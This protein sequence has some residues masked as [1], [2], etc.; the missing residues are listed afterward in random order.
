MPIR[1]RRRFLQVIDLES[2]DTGRDSY[3]MDI[4]GFIEFHGEM[5]IFYEFKYKNTPMPEGQRLAYAHVV[6]A[7][8]EAGKYAAALICE[9]DVDDADED[10]TAGETIIRE[11]YFGH[12]WVTMSHLLTVNDATKGIL[13]YWRR[14]EDEKHGQ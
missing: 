7:L 11:A 13:N 2:I 4:D 12:G 6:D 14:L 10:V 8:R 9:H 5:F 1:N 3:P